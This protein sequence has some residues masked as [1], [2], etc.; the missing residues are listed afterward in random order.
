MTHKKKLTQAKAAMMMKD[1][2]VRG[3]A[4][5]EKQK[6]LFGM[7]AGGHTPTRMMAQKPARRRKTKKRAR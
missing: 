3:H 2:M 4:L 7:M 6:G 5:T 1:G